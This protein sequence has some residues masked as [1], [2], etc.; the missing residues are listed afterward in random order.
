MPAAIAPRALRER[1]IRNANHICFK[2]T[3]GGTCRRSALT[4]PVVLLHTPFAGFTRTPASPGIGAA[5][6]SHG[7]ATATSRA[8]LLCRAYPRTA[9]R[10]QITLTRA[11][12]ASFSLV[13]L[14]LGSG[15]GFFSYFQRE[16]TESVKPGPNTLSFSSPS[17]VMPVAP[18]RP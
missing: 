1:P 4:N 6:R 14:P 10:L 11:H 18:S 13:V 3:A 8:Q 5:R 17:A 7:T 2:F 16:R 9:A 15:G 12:L